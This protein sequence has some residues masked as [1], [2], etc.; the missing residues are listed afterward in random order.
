MEGQD[1]LKLVESI[2]NS[3][4]KKV[5]EKEDREQKKSEETELFYRCKERCIS[6]HIICK[7]AKLKQCPMCRI[8]MKSVCGKSKCI[9]DGKRPIMI[10]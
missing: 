6:D 1:L 10:T 2:N 5:Q 8:F 4:E 9:V 7:A 3:K